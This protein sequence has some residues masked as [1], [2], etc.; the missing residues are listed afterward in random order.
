MGGIPAL[1]FLSCAGYRIA[2]MVH[3]KFWSIFAMPIGVLLCFGPCIITWILSGT[4]KPAQDEPARGTGQN[5]VT[6]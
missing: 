6:H 2:D 1:Y 3:D 4:E 5:P